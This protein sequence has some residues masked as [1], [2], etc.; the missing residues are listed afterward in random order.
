MRWGLVL[1]ALAG[2]VLTL[3]AVSTD[4]LWARVSVFE[5]QGSYASESVDVALGDVEKAWVGVYRIGMLSLV[6]LVA[7]AVAGPRRV[8]RTAATMALAVAAVTAAALALGWADLHDAAHEFAQGAIVVGRSAPAG[9]VTWSIGR[10]AMPVAAT[11]LA[12]LTVVAA[13]VVWPRHRARVLA[14]AG[15]ASALL[16]IGVPFALAWLPHGPDDVAA[17]GYWLPSAGGSGWLA[18]VLTIGLTMVAALAARSPGSRGFVVAAVVLAAAAGGAAGAVGL[19][20]AQRAT[21][22]AGAGYAEATFSPMFLALA[23]V[24]LVLAVLAAARRP[25]DAG[26]PGGSTGGAVSP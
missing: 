20:P 19:D 14:A 18:I 4:W 1:G 12:V 11:G 21:Y 17:R 3:L 7:V 23:V 2:C 13:Q 24:F 10:S 6:A 9:A 26:G 16:W 8:R 5:G 25:A 22:R 15:G